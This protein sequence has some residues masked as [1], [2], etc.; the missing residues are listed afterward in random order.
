LSS[1]A[2]VKTTTAKRIKKLGRGETREAIE[3]LAVK[4]KE[5][6]VKGK[7]KKQNA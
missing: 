4:T 5:K 6:K 2:K 3:A 7:E 1:Q